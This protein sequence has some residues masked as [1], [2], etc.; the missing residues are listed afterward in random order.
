MIYTLTANPAIDYNISCDG[1]SANTVTRT[2]DA[3][4]SPNGKGLNVSFA[5][6]HFGVDTAIL[7]FFAGFSGRFIVEGA[8]AKGV[9][10]HPVWT[11]GIT[12]DRIPSTTWLTPVPPC[13]L[14]TSRPCA[15]SSTRLRT[16]IAS[17]S[18]ARCPRA[19]PR[20]SWPVSSSAFAPAAPS[21]CWISRARSSPS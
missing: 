21:S 15:S 18:R 17:S 11:E 12:P 5:L 4:Y 9:D 13:A 14:P 20:T 3:V 19:R 8:R 10:V 6:N 7:G 16:S 1:L 2:R